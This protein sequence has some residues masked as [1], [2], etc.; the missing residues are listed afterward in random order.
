MNE[1]FSD[2]AEGSESPYSNGTSKRACVMPKELKSLGSKAEDSESYNW[3]AVEC[4][5]E[6]TSEL[7]SIDPCMVESESSEFESSYI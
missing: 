5:D 1:D 4:I 7:T 2:G 3:D 6:D